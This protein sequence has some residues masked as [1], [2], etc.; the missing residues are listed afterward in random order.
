VGLS[1]FPGDEERLAVGRVTPRAPYR[2]LG[3]RGRQTTGRPTIFKLQ[4]FDFAGMGLCLSMIRKVLYVDDDL[5]S[6]MIVA[7]YLRNLGYNILTVEDAD[8]ALRVAA[9]NNVDV[10]IL[11]VNRVGL[12]GPELMGKLQRILPG[13]PIILFSGV[14]GSGAKVTRM[15]EM[16]AQQFVSKNDPLDLL[17]KALQSTLHPVH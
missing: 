5:D 15:L 2:R 10:M 9:E 4:P 1:R 16:G 12:D 6:R 17:V 7:D 3:R 11:D 13:V 14:L 8:D